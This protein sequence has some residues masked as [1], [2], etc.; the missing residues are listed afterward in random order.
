LN[1]Q[2][3]TGSQVHTTYQFSSDCD[4]GEGG[5][6]TGTPSVYHATLTYDGP[7]KQGIPEKTQWYI[8]S[9]VFRGSWCP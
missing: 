4:A 7:W 1:L 5:L 6:D 2:N 8:K 9:R 3:L